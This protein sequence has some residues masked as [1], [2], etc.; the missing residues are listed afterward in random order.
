[1]VDGAKAAIW[2][3]SALLTASLAILRPDQPLLV[4][5]SRL[6]ERPAH[7]QIAYQTS[8]KRGTHRNA[9]TRIMIASRAVVG[10]A[11]GACPLRGMGWSILTRFPS[12]SVN[13][14]YRPTP[15]ISIG[16]PST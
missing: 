7:A 13:E 1:V 3:A 14:T 10:S 16:S 4:R 12:V 11:F 15:G 2:S 8:G 9:L 5:K 6:L